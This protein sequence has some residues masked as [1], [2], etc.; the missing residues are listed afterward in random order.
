MSKYTV[1]FKL[2][3][4]DEWVDDGFELTLSLLK[5]IIEDNILPY[6]YTYEKHVSCVSIVK[7]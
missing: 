5:E 1:S 2:E 6:A 7:Y 3:I 4:A